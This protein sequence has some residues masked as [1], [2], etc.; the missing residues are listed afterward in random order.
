MSLTQP[1]RFFTSARTVKNAAT[2]CERWFGGDK[3][4]NGRDLV[5]VMV[6]LV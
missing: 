2:P 3:E 5:G 4:A 1:L 6:G